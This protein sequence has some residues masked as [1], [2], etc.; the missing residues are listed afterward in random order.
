MIRNRK[1]KHRIYARDWA[2]YYSSQSWRTKREAVKAFNSEH[3][4]Q[5]EM[6]GW[7]YDLVRGSP[8]TGGIVIGRV[9][10]VVDRRDN[11]RGKLV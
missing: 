2:G 10:I 1:R 6:A 3:C 11:L 4:R 5:Y 7:E 8:A 9:K